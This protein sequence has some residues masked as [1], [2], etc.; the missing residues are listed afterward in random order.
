MKEWFKRRYNL[1]YKPTYRVFIFIVAAVVM[2]L[3]FPNVDKMQYEYELQRPWRYENII[4]PY[5]FPIYKTDQEIALE[6]DSILNNFRPYYKRDS[7]SIKEITRTVNKMLENYR[8]KVSMIC[9]ASIRQDSLQIYIENILTRSLEK[10]YK[11]GVLE[12]PEMAEYSNE[13][14]YELMV[15]HGNIMEPF[16][17]GELLTM[18]EAYKE[19]VKDMETSL[20]K[21]Y[22]SAATWTGV[23]V[24][25]LPLSDLINTNIN[26]DGERTSSERDE[27]LANMS[28]SSG[29][30]LSGQKIIST[31][32]IVDKRSVRL[33]ES[34]KKAIETQHGLV[35]R[36]LPVYIGQFIMIMCFLTT[37]YL[38]L[39]FFR[40]DVFQKLGSINFIVL[41]MT[42]FVVGAGII[43]QK[44]GN[45]SFVVPFVVSPI[46][47]RI[48]LDSRLAMYVHTITILII[49]F[50]AYNSQLFILLHIP[51][52]MVAIISLVNLTRRGQIVRT[53]VVVFLTYALIYIGHCIWQTGDYDNINPYILAMFAVNGLFM[54]LSYPLI[55]VF[56]RMFGF[57]SDVTLL[58]L[59]DSNNELLR[60]LSEKAPGTFQHSVQVGNLG[61]EVAIRIGANGMMVRA[62]AMY[63][64]IGKIVT[65]GYFTENQAGGINPHDGMDYM[66]SSQMIIKHVENGQRL[67]NKYNIPQQIIDIIKTH[68]GMSQARYFY[69][70][71][72]NEHKDMEPDMSKFTYPGPLPQTKE[73]AIVMMADA[74]E[75][76]SKSLKEYTDKSIDELVDKIINMQMDSKQFREAPITFR[77]IE[78]AKDVFKEKLKN[79]Y[80]G[81]IQYPELLK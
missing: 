60:E 15:I 59:S 56:E 54:L 49:S 40:K 2:V 16:T 51:A 37:V 3:S 53:S 48:F 42:S 18:G 73:Q 74:V 75:A 46:V 4:A 19:L 76:S 57:I 63:H 71:W 29:K 58:E 5:D 9:P 44:H 41:V 34:L 28:L 25:R 22:G 39:R 50:L 23:L 7:V 1:Y 27:R 36:G 38:F 68:H 81:R 72:C 24:D 77:D 66:E 11:Q 55:Y 10:I 78:I 12:M 79:I 35:N 47:M 6:R 52:G 20:Y 32:D 21:R 30:V 8:G 70:S 80:H 65:P 61:Q 69:I 31:G 64:D 67:A 13:K 33:I 14:T 26:Y 43:S 62:G 45:I 17:L